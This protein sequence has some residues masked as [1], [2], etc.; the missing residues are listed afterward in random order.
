[1][2]TC[3]PIT[4]SREWSIPAKMCDM[5]FP[6]RSRLIVQPEQPGIGSESPTEKQGT[7]YQKQREG[8]QGR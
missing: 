8:M 7:I 2:P 5:S 4:V 6:G 1:M 3:K